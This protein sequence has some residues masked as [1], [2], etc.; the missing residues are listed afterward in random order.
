MYTHLSLYINIYR[1]NVYKYIYI[2]IYIY[3]HNLSVSLSLYIY[4]YIYRAPAEC[5]VTKIASPE[6]QLA[7]RRRSRTTGRISSQRIL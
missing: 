3:I 2:Y 1:C 7:F 5:P 6:R 4:T